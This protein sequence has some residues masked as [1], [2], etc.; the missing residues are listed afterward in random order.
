[1]RLQNG[2]TGDTPE[3]F[4]AFGG[5]ALV[6]ALIV[7]ARQFFAR[8][9]LAPAHGFSVRVDEDAVR[10]ALVDKSVFLAAIAHATFGPRAEPL[11]LG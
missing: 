1:M 2:K 11:L 10:A 5:A 7:N 4:R 3:F 6:D 8:T 9:V